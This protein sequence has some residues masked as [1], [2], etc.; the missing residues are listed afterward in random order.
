MI[1]ISH[2][3][4]GGTGMR[5]RPSFIIAAVLLLSPCL[6]GQD[7]SFIEAQIRR[8]QEVVAHDP[9]D[10]ETL[11]AIGAGYGNSEITQPP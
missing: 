8:W 4:M 1:E 2:P 6:Y 9:N 3:Y 5:V 10:Y 11:A 7:R